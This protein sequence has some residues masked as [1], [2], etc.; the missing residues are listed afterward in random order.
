MM[1]VGHR[2]ELKLDRAT[3]GL[4]GDAHELVGGD[5]FVFRRWVTWTPAAFTGGLLYGFSP[6]MVAEGNGHLF[7]VAAAPLPPLILW[8]IDRAV[9]RQQGTPWRNGALL[10][11]LLFLQ[12]MISA[13]VMA[14]ILVLLAFAAVL[15][16]ASVWLEP[17]RQPRRSDRT[18]PLAR[19]KRRY[20][21]PRT[22]PM[23]KQT[24][25]TPITAPLTTILSRLRPTALAAGIVFLLLA[26]YP[27]WV[28][29]A[30]PEHILGPAQPIT[31]VKGLSTDL[32]TPIVP[33]V[34]QLL[35]FGYAWTGTKFVAEHGQTLLP[36]G[37]ENGGYIGL[38]LLI[39]I[40]SGIILLR[41][42]R[43][44]RTAAV[45]A[46]ASLLLSMGS[47]LHVAGRFVG[48][49]LPFVV[50]THLPLFDSQIASRYTLFMW[51]FLALILAIVMERCH[52]AIA[53]QVRRRASD[54]SRRATHV[55]AS[56]GVAAV[57]LIALLPL[58]PN[59]PG[60]WQKADIPRWFTSPDAA[61]VPTGS[62]LITYP[63]PSVANPQ[64]MVWQAAAHMRFR[65][66]GGYLITPTTH[67]IATFQ[68]APSAIEELLGECSEG[69]S[70]T[71]V[72][73]S[74]AA[75]V[76]AQIRAW[77]VSAVVV[78]PRQQGNPCAIRVFTYALGKPTRQYG[79]YVWMPGAKA[80]S[81]YNYK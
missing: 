56:G 53:S 29:I 1:V 63:Y 9:V 14:S 49:P 17:S 34:N 46:A 50:L 69:M 15:G 58:L 18:P 57:A 64:P 33:T 8:V 47:E 4:E 6:Y 70:A 3:L 71:A 35:S 11:L 41:R 52:T 42:E 13:E 74:A 39:V 30:G 59:W 24:P 40:I 60:P 51:L 67:G 36:D 20:T 19:S 45:M 26:A 38:T 79:S 72:S 25:S 43:V 48:V 28:G 44:V 66:P 65:M 7:L 61:K 77:H 23:R 76:S 68:P 78:P 32:L 55:V 80:S 75:S 12:L 54:A 5:G 16:V 21:T 73:P 81:S 27:I 37:S 2:A 22:A 62:T 31:L 10:G